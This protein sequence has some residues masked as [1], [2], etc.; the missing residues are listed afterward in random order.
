MVKEMTHLDVYIWRKTFYDSLAY[1]QTP[2][3]SDIM[4]HFLAMLVHPYK[5]DDGMKFLPTKEWI[6]EFVDAY[7]D[8]G[9]FK[10][11]ERR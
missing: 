1:S 10:G 8:D 6:S 5:Q 9:H 7:D 11:L 2:L 3:P 4:Q